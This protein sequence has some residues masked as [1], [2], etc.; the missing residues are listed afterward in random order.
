MIALSEHLRNHGYDPTVEQHTRI[1]GIW[2]KLRTLYNLDVID[3]REN[4]F[5]Y[6]EPDKFLDFKLPEAE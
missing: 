1:P 3:E 2:Q 4:S 6:D 5:D